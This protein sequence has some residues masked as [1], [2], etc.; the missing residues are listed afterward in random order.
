MQINKKSR[1]SVN[2]PYVKGTGT[3]IEG[4]LRLAYIKPPELLNKALVISGF[5][6]NIEKSIFIDTINNRAKRKINFLHIERLDRKYS[7]WGTVVVELNNA[8]YA[9]LSNQGFWE[10][11]MQIREWKG[12]RFWRGKRPARIKPQDI[13]HQVRNQWPGQLV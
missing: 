13:K 7:K 1:L 2:A 11:E 4:S 8:D 5:D 12:W 3:A 9:T 10:V 6:R